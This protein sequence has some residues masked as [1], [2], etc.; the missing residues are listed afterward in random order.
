LTADIPA[1]TNPN[2]ACTAWNSQNH[3]QNAVDQINN[4]ANNPSQIANSNAPPLNMD[5]LSFR[6]HHDIEVRYYKAAHTSNGDI[7]DQY[8]ETTSLGKEAGVRTPH[9]VGWM[10]PDD[11][12]MPKI[13]AASSAGAKT[14]VGVGF[15]CV[16]KVDTGV[17]SYPV[18]ARAKA[19]LV[20]DSG[21]SGVGGSDS[22]PLCPPGKHDCGPGGFK[23]TYWVKLAPEPK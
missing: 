23:P 6:V 2:L 16:E 19:F 14:R 5:P 8:V 22:S 1:L 18:T 15:A 4:L 10:V 13:D 21:S 7:P 17:G 20:E 3:E 9:G 12:K 11:Q